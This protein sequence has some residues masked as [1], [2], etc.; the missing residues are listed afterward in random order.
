MEEE[1]RWITE[2]TLRSRTHGWPILS[3]ER[4]GLPWTPCAM[5]MVAGKCG[6]TSNE[7][8]IQWMQRTLADLNA[9]IEGSRSAALSTF[10]R[11]D[12]SVSASKS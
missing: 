11:P 12:F 9:K 6:V 1:Y 10:P 4:V 7:K 8:D 5:Q 3:A 2:P